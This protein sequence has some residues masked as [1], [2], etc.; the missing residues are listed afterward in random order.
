MYE[1]SDQLTRSRKPHP[2]F[3]LTS[4]IHQIDQPRVLRELQLF[5]MA[6]QTFTYS[7]VP[8]WLESLLKTHAPNS[9]PL[10]RRLQFAKYRG[11]TSENSSIIFICQSDIQNG[12]SEGQES[13]QLPLPADAKFTAVYVDLAGGPETQM[14]LYSTIEDGEKENNQRSADDMRVYEQQMEALVKEM[15]RLSKEYGKPLAL[16]NGVL[17]GTLNTRVRRI[18][19]GMNRIKGRET[20]YYDKWLF[21]GHDF[22]SEG[23]ELPLGLKWDTATFEDCKIVVARTDIPRTPWVSFP[24]LYYRMS[25]LT[26]S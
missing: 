13:P 5:S 9:L 8:D 12:T 26:Q 3:V 23:E 22:P 7:H 20:G 10:L 15:I 17:L 25:V 6:S 14:W 16:P 19:E 11:C 21:K 1:S 4:K 2:T 18:L 24:F